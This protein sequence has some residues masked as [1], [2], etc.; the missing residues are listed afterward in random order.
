MSCAAVV[1]AKPRPTALAK[2]VGISVGYASLLLSDA[3]TPPLDLAV[4]I[5]RETGWRSGPLVDAPE[6]EIA[7]LERYVAPAVERSAA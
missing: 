5:F 7:V 6:D 3:K 4:R 2:A 1:P